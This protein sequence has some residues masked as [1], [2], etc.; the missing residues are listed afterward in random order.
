MPAVLDP[1]ARSPSTDQ[2]PYCCPQPIFREAPGS[3]K[4]IRKGSTPAL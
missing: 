3:R 2:Q 4:R 1:S